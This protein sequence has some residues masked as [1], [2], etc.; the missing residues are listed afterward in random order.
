MTNLVIGMGE[1]GSAVAGVLSEEYIVVTHDKNHEDIIDKIDVIHICFGYSEDFIDE[2]QSY[3]ERFNPKLVIIYSTVPIG[4]T[5]KFGPQVVHSPIEGKH[6]KLR[7]STKLF[8]RY[9][10]YTNLDAA[11]MAYKLWSS[12]TEVELVDNPNHTEFLKLA[13]TSKY[14][15]NIVWA[16]YMKD[17]SDEIGMDYELVK[18]WDVAYN[19]LYTSMH[20]PEYR[21]FILDAEDGPIGGHCVVPNAELLNEQFPN[22][23]L[24][25]IKGAK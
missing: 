1:V 6:P 18:D 12:I 2:V 9:I 25:I 14:G 8:K 17:V 20:L 13:S 23:M 10:G 21:K 22:Q 11:I 3:I 15:I 19:K 4:T 16:K 5:R 24:T 7:R